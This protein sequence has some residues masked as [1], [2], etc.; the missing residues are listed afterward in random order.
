MDHTNTEG[1]NAGAFTAPAIL[2]NLCHISEAMSSSITM[3]IGHEEFR[4]I[5]DVAATKDE[6]DAMNAGDPTPL[7]FKDHWDDRLA[8]SVLYELSDGVN[9]RDDVDI[10]DSML[11]MHFGEKGPLGK[12][13]QRGSK[14]R[15]Y[16]SIVYDRDIKKWIVGGAL[17]VYLPSEASAKF[18]WGSGGNAEEMANR[19]RARKA[20][21]FATENDDGA[22]VNAFPTHRLQHVIE[23]KCGNDF[24]LLDQMC[25]ETPGTARRLVLRAIV[26]L[27]TGR[28]KKTGLVAVGINV[29]S[30][31][32]F[33]DFGFKEAV[34]NPHE[35]WTLYYLNELPTLRAL[36]KGG[37]KNQ[38]DI[39]PVKE[40]LAGL[41]YRPRVRGADDGKRFSTGCRL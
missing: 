32:I 9:C 13:F 17:T 18:L 15:L 23:N 19:K 2:K 16:T 35:G 4:R 39:R 7:V 6:F 38:D 41:C 11:T 34:A 31:R 22:V 24:A 1:L 8:A 26:E 25:S 37:F 10:V 33:D 28:Y 3:H 27:M 12:A 21:G 36:L 20:L 14:S 40:L 29:H 5:V 30:K